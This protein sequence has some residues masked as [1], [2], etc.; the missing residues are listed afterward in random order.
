MPDLLTH[1]LFSK[2]VLDKIEDKNIAK[3]IK[4]KQILFQL[5]AQG[6]DFLFY[7]KPFLPFLKKVNKIGNSMHMKET[8]NFF[9]NAIKNLESLK[10]NEYNDLLVYV[11]GFLCHYYLDKEIHPYV[12]FV[13][14]YGVWDY[15][16]IIHQISHY[17][18]EYTLDI[19]LWK[20]YENKNAYET[21]D[22]KMIY[23]KKIPESVLSYLEKYICNYQ[24]VKITRKELKSA[25]KSMFWVNHLLYDPKKKKRLLR[26]IPAPRK[27]YK[28]NPFSNLDVE[29]SNHNKWHYINEKEELTYSVIDL[30]NIAVSDCSKI[31]NSI[32]SQLEGDSN[33]KIMIEI[34]NL[35]Y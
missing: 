6:P 2:L 35:E 29:N 3:I 8:A 21:D 19:R 4:E 22:S 17:Y 1:T 33:N 34:P 11:L 14:K 27:F 13:E 32:I 26:M 10:G 18:L 9:I 30:I 16:N 20:K 28:K 23:T 31:A 15:N 7:Y 25:F 24:K 12:Y 5:G